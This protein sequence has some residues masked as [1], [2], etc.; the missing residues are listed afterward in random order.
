MIKI[1]FF[2][3]DSYT[4][5]NVGSGGQ[6]WAERWKEYSVQDFIALSLPFMAV[7]TFLAIAITI[8]LSHNMEFL[9]YSALPPNWRNPIT[10]IACSVLDLWSVAMIIAVGN[11]VLQL[12]AI[13][14]DVLIHNLLVIGSSTGPINCRQ[15][16]SKIESLR[17]LQMY[18]LLVNIANCYVLFV[19]KVAAISLAVING[20]AAIAHFQH[21]PMLHRLM[22][23]VV[24]FDGFACYCLIYQKGF[25]VPQKFEEVMSKLFLCLQRSRCQQFSGMERKI[26]ERQLRSIPKFGIKVGEFHM[27]ERQSTPNFL[28]FVLKN[29]VNLLVIYR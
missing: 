10:L 22:N 24:F 19:F 14:F 7:L 28:D 25:Q 8:V 20:Y 13:V 3:A 16:V 2:Y 11:P 26:I 15:L 29:V 12:H 23:Y 1:I 27:L 18:V 21:H 17:R 5:S 9:I 4:G 6:R